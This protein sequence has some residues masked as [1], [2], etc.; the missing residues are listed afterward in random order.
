MLHSP[1]EPVNEACGSVSR[2][3]D[4]MFTDPPKVDGP[5]DAAEPGLRSN[6]VAPTN[7]LGKNAHEWWDGSFVSLKGMPSNVIEYCVSEKPR[8]NVFVSPRPTPLGCTLNV[9]GAMATIWL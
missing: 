6:R 9:P 4:I 8:K 7:W 5:I 2:V 1:Y 3:R